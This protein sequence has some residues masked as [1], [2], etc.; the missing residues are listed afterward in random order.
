MKKFLMAIV[1]IVAVFGLTTKP[2]NAAKSACTTIQSGNLLN[3]LGAVITTGYDQ[4]GYN[5]QANMFNG[6]YCDAYHND[7]WCQQFKDVNLMMKWNNAWLSNQDCDGDKL[8]DRHY[9]F[10]SYINSG[11]WLTNHATGTYTSTEK[12]NW[13]V[14]G[15][16][17]LDFAGGT[18]N[19]EFINLV[20][21]AAGNV[22]GEFWWLTGGNFAYG[23]AL[24]GT[25][26]GDTLHLDYDRAP[27]LYTGV[28]DGTIGANVITAGTFSDSNGNQLTWTATGTSVKVY[29]TCT[30]SDFVKIV[31]APIGATMVDENWVAADG[32]VI[33]PAIWGDFAVIQEIASD[34]CGEYGVID[35]MSP[36]RKGLGN[37]S[38]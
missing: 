32:S 24:V 30:V 31:A 8:L 37:W 29:D 10:A 13:N 21:D 16:W 38:K 9:G 20:Q 3:S 25:V 2:V 18:D 34:P 14:S 33:G 19:R 26:S 36:L 5:Y 23:G 7:A 11:A 28:F 35:Y 12:F 15:N 4:W 22:T 27:I 1:A 17:L 6:K